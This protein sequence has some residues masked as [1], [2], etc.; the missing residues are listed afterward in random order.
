M[1]AKPS[2]YLS[3]KKFTPEQVKILYE[4]I[5]THNFNA[6]KSNDQLFL[7]AVNVKERPMSTSIIPK[8]RTFSA[9]DN[10]KTAFEPCF[11]SPLWPLGGKIRKRGPIAFLAS[12]LNSKIAKVWTCQH[13]LAVLGL[14]PGLS[15]NSMC[16]KVS[17]GV[18]LVW[19]MV[20]FC[21]F[22]SNSSEPV[23]T[24]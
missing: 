15:T 12:F 9:D 2:R 5:L 10:D 19:C 18:S 6:R 13:T 20:F 17:V 7:L 14:S 21:P 16:P 8:D 4:P 23:R 3:D 22:T 1:S 11:L 24:L